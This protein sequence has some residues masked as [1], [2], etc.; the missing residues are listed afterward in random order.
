MEKHEM[1]NRIE[2]RIA[3]RIKTGCYLELLTPET[4][5]LFGS[6]KTRIAKDKNGEDVPN[7]E[8][9]EVVLVRCNIV[10]GYQQDS[11]VLLHLFLINCLIYY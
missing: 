10:N 5:K 1:E 9:N 6:T 4:M 7:L 11:R 3:F 8:I 2:N